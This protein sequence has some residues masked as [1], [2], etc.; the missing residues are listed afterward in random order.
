LWS[1]DSIWRKTFKRL[2]K[3]DQT[4]CLCQ[5]KS[6]TRL[7]ENKKKLRNHSRRREGKSNKGK[8]IWRRKAFTETELEA[9]STWELLEGR[10]LKS[11]VSERECEGKAR[12][13]REGE[14]LERRRKMCRLAKWRRRRNPKKKLQEK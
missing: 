13:Y 9:A 8:V 3:K 1:K 12:K 14:K 5:L 6:V 10:G 7:K 4:V 2:I 11:K